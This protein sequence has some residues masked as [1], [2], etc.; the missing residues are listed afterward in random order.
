[1][2]RSSS[3]ITIDWND[4]D[5]MDLEHNKQIELKLEEIKKQFKIKNHNTEKKSLVALKDQMK[6]LT[7]IHPK[8]FSTSN[9]LPT[10]NIVQYAIFKHDVFGEFFK[11][12]WQFVG[13]IGLGPHALKRKILH[14]EMRIAKTKPVL[15]DIKENIDEIEDN[16]GQIFDIGLNIDE[17]IGRALDNLDGDFSDS[18]DDEPLPPSPPSSPDLD[19]HLEIPWDELNLEGLMS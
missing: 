4:Q 17:N 10:F 9:I 8:H 16:T 14:L 5:A 12:I 1:M 11:K 18:N 7:P 3:E 2:K 6:L 19:R 13:Y 15:E